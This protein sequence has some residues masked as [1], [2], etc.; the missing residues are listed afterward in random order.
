MGRFCE[1][2]VGRGEPS[3]SPPSIVFSSGIGYAA[4][5]CHLIRGGCHGK[6]RR[7]GDR[8]A[9]KKDQTPRNPKDVRGGR[10]TPNLIKACAT[11]E[12][13]KEATITV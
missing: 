1:S 4:G 6:G 13:T 10:A 3:A 9:V 11:G 7:K 2:N 5:A 12:H 8:R